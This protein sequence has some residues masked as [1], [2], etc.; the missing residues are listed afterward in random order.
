MERIDAGK[1]A[2]RSGTGTPRFVSDFYVAAFV[3]SATR[4]WTI[5]GV[6]I[7]S[8]LSC[9]FPCTTPPKAFFVAAYFGLS[10]L[11]PA[12]LCR[13]TS[14]QEDLNIEARTYS[15]PSAEY[16]QVMKDTA[17]SGQISAILLSHSSLS[18]IETQNASGTGKYASW[19]P[20]DQDCESPR[21]VASPTIWMPLYCFLSSNSNRARSPGNR[22]IHR[23]YLLRTGHLRRSFKL[24][25]VGCTWWLPSL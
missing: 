20:L 9:T 21:R 3:P 8:S 23:R 7:V 2:G 24:V 1:L 6:R 14:V 5:C 13:H 25:Q 10:R 19:S 22:A 18:Q 12:S 16:L 4:H 17:T 11:A 15:L